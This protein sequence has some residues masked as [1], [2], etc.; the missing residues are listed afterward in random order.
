M[1]E[2]SFGA[3]LGN[4]LLVLNRVSRIALLYPEDSSQQDEHEAGVG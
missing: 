2:T 4:E 1:K 3:G